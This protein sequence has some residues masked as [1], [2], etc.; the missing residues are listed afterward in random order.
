MKISLLGLKVAPIPTE[1]NKKSPEVWHV[2]IK[3]SREEIP[4]K[5]LPSAHEIKVIILSLFFEVDE[6]KSKTHI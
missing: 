1:G 4:R 5:V 2:L 6:R 3:D